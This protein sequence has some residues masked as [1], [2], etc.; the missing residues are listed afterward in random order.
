MSSVSGVDN[1]FHL[2]YYSF[3]SNVVHAG[4]VA[5]VTRFVAVDAACA[6]SVVALLC[7]CELHLL[8][9]LVADGKGRLP[10]GAY[11]ARDRD[12]EPLIDI[13]IDGGAHG[14]VA[15]WRKAVDGYD[16]F[17]VL[18]SIVEVVGTLREADG[19]T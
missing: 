15:R 6:A 10:L 11:V 1:L 8:V 12:L 4:K 18:V 2:I 5:P 3:W 17:Y 9:P 14:F 16:V 19:L 7:P 13:D